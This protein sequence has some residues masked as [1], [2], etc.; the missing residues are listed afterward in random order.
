MRKSEPH[1]LWCVAIAIAIRTMTLLR[2]AIASTSAV[3]VQTART[4]VRSQASFKPALACHA[5]GSG[6]RWLS[7]SPQRPAEVADVG[8]TPAKVPNAPSGAATQAGERPLTRPAHLSRE[9]FEAKKEEKFA[10]YEALLR[11]KATKC[12]SR[13]DNWLPT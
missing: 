1:V 13:L 6:A 10:K 3:V 12:V 5:S 8:V 11:E 4:A 9:A 7:N 2:Q